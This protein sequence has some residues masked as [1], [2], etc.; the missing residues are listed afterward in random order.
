MN[1]DVLLQ[2]F[3][4]AENFPTVV[5]GELLLIVHGHV[6]PQVLPLL[7]HLAAKVASMLLVGM[8]LL[9][10]P[11]DVSADELLATE[12]AVVSDVL[13]HLADVIRQGS[14][15]RVRLVALGTLEGLS[16]GIGMAQHVVLHLGFDYHPTYGTL[17][18]SLLGSGC[19]R[20]LCRFGLHL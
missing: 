3:V 15:K 5:A 6:L 4:K 19:R 12:I 17:I 7:E 11:Q 16:R 20:R 9:V 8:Q 1:P 13:M 18:A 14:L 10:N 2:L